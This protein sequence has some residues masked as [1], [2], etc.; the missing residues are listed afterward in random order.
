M[1]EDDSSFIL[2]SNTG[3]QLTV[4]RG[5]IEK[6]FKAIPGNLNCKD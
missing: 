2:M 5:I 6:Y 3:E 4:S 1:T